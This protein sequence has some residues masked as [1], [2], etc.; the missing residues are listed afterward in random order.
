MDLPAAP[1]CFLLLFFFFEKT[2]FCFFWVF[3]Q[4]VDQQKKSYPLI[5]IV[6]SGP[7]IG[8]GPRG[9]EPN[10]P[11]PN[12]LGPDAPL[13]CALCVLARPMAI[14]IIMIMGLWGA[15]WGLWGLSICS[16]LPWSLW[17]SW[18]PSM[19]CVNVYQRVL[20]C[21]LNIVSFIDPR[22]AS[23]SALVAVSWK[24]RLTSIQQT[25]IHSAGWHLS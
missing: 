24:S 15:R 12:G 13:S 21:W 4:K 23:E 1:F 7:F 25:D 19:S 6:T 16:W 8:P 3:G 10:G 17:T 9:P 11:G 2:R 14:I 18:C 22:N 20:G 5:V